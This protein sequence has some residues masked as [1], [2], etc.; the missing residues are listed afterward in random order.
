MAVRSALALART[1]SAGH[2]A[3]LR[4]LADLWN[5]LPPENETDYG[6]EARTILGRRFATTAP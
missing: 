1:P 2:E 3:D 4:L 5:R 6:R